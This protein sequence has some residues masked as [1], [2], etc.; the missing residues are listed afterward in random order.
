MLPVNCFEL[1]LFSFL[2]N[3]FQAFLD[4]HGDILPFAKGLSFI[5]SVWGL[6]KGARGALK[7]PIGSSSYLP[8]GACACVC[9]FDGKCAIV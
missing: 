3:A 7:T 2:Y 9:V 8:M 4:T 5:P 1:F 6:C